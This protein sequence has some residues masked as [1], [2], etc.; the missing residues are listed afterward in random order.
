MASLERDENRKVVGAG[1]SITDLLTPNPLNVDP[2]TN[3]LL[4]DVT[5]DSSPSSTLRAR[6]ARDANHV[7]TAYGVSDTDGNTPLPLLIDHN[8]NYLFVDIAT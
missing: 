7:P 4:I 3:R 8:N 2:V 1:I 5:I 6:D